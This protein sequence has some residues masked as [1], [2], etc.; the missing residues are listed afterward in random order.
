MK[1]TAMWSILL[2]LILSAC[3]SEQGH[4]PDHERRI[5]LAEQKVDKIMEMMDLPEYGLVKM[6][7]EGLYTSD[8]FLQAGTDMIKHG[9]DMKGIDYPDED[10][11]KM[12]QE[13]LDAF[14]GFEVALKSKNEADI[15]ANWEA[16]ALTCKKCHDVYD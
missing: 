13:M 12:N 15:K 8:D 3:K 16:V 14:D 1:H 11:L 7:K 10:F 9:R 2:I 4:G 6:A 5:K